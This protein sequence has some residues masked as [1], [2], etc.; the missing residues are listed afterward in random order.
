LA[1]YYKSFFE[2]VAALSKPLTQLTLKD[3]KFCWSEPQQTSFDAL[4]EALT[5]EAVLGHPVF[6]KNLY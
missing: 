5:S 3:T 2:N 4:K 6:D 1:S